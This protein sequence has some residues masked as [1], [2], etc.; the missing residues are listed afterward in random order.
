MMNRILIISAGLFALMLSACDNSS[1]PN[2]VHQFPDP[3]NRVATDI[4]LFVYSD[5]W[6]IILDTIDVAE[7]GSVTIDIEEENP[8]YD[9][10]QYYIYAEADGFYTEL[11]YCNKGETIDVDLDAVPDVENSITGVVFGQQTYFADC[12]FAEQSVALSVPGGESFTSNT[13]AQGRFGFSALD[14]S[15][16][17]L[18][19]QESGIPHTFELSNSSGTDYYDL[20]FMESAQERAPNLYLYPES[21][22]TVSV[23]L[24][25]AGE[26]YIS[27]SQPPYGNGWNVTV[28]PEG[29]ID[30]NYNYLFYE[31][32]ISVQLN[33]YTGWLLNGDDLETELENVLNKYGF[34]EREIDDFMEYWLPRLGSAPWFA[35]YPQKADSLVTLD[36]SPLPDNILRAV[37]LI[38]PLPKPVS[39][40]PPPEPSEFTRTGFT[41]VEWGMILITE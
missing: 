13:D 2:D 16:Y 11:Y 17:I 22:T 31:V 23:E 14:E 20:T 39:I 4:Q 25:I 34:T 26:G 40:P 30:D 32:T 36:I 38:R 7:E 27:E 3:V 1:G 6:G 8:Y 19:L 24:D 35:L 18:H 28:T 9:P 41:A 12:Y 21:T 29:I 15:T 37:F 33:H 10:P 5:G